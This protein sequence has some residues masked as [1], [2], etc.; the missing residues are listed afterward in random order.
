MKEYQSLI[1]QVIIAVAIVIAGVLIAQAI[2]SAGGN[3][4]SGLSYIGELIRD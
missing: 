2:T 3:I 4:N 1:G